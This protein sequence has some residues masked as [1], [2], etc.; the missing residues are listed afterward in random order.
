MNYI[1]KRYKKYGKY[2]QQRLSSKRQV[3]RERKD[4]A[5]RRFRPEYK[6]QISNAS[7][8]LSSLHNLHFSGL[9][10]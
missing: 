5:G 1:I 9:F 3:V 2:E 8:L 10:I 4:G 6:E 7:S